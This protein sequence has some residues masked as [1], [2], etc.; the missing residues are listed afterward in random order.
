[1]GGTELRPTKEPPSSEACGEGHFVVSL[2]F[3]LGAGAVVFGSPVALS[4]TGLATSFFSGVDVEVEG[5][6]SPLG[7]AGVSFLTSG[8]GGVEVADSSGLQPTSAADSAAASA[9]VA[10]SCLVMFFS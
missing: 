5:A 1:M 2:I 3:L 9:N 8:A 10:N 4:G 6:G 7:V